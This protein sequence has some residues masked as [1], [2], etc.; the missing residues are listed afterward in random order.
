MR[1]AYDSYL[2]KVRGIGME[3][4]VSQLEPAVLDTEQR[5][6]GGECR[7]LAIAMNHGE[8]W[9]FLQMVNQSTGAARDA[10]VMIAPTIHR[11]L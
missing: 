5:E 4:I 1:V 9:R 3:R 11:A 8:P 10:G 6:M 2:T 7:L